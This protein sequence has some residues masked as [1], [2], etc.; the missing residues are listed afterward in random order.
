MFFFF[1][2]ILVLFGCFDSSFLL[3]LE[4][5]NEDVGARLYI[6]YLALLTVLDR[7][8]AC[9]YDC[10]ELHFAFAFI[11]FTNFKKVEQTV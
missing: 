3:E 11:W 5:K 10:F 1:L 7:S 9:D 2:L 6:P 8:R 4:L